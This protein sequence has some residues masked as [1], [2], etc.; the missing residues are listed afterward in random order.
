MF[1]KPEEISTFIRQRAEE[2]QTAAPTL[3]GS[4]DYADA[5]ANKSSL[6]PS[7][8][9]PGGSL[10]EPDSTAS[11]VQPKPGKRPPK[12]VISTMGRRNRVGQEGPAIPAQAKRKLPSL[13]LKGR[14]SGFSSRL[15]HL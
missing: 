4:D 12:P 14:K 7:A 15:S 11:L 5:S 9:K 6:I 3:L 13:N 1:S 2:G 10:A 8:S